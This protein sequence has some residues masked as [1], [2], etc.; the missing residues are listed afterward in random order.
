MKQIR[1]ET[2]NVDETIWNK[3]NNHTLNCQLFDDEDTFP[4]SGNIICL[5]SV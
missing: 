4:I 2:S 1:I 5:L 3:L